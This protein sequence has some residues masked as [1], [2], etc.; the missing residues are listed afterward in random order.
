MIHVQS[1]L[2]ENKHSMHVS[3]GNNSNNNVPLYHF[4]CDSNLSKKNS[5][6]SSNG[7]KSHLS[8]TT[9]KSQL[10]LQQI[11]PS[12]SFQPI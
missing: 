10:I 3:F 6:V 7:A 2:A 9:L 4:G 8:K 11:H 1:V 12:W 5:L